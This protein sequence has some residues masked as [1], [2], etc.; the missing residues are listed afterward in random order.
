MQCS[1][2]VNNLPEGRSLVLPQARIS[3]HTVDNEITLVLRETRRT[4]GWSSDIPPLTWHAH[5]ILIIFQF[6]SCKIT[7]L[8]FFSLL[9]Y[10][11]LHIETTLWMTHQL[12]QLLRQAPKLAEQRKEVTCD[13][14]HAEVTIKLTYQYHRVTPSPW[15]GW[16]VEKLYHRVGLAVWW[17]W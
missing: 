10:R 1:D 16:W 3:V 5:F 7:T 14:S 4:T 8:L 11:S 2:S 6:K 12:Q 9:H 13:C 17:N 15:G